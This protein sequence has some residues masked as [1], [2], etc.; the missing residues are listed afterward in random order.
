MKRLILGLTAGALTLLCGCKP[1][2]L[3]AWETVSDTVVEAGSVWDGTYTITVGVPADAVEQDADS[4]VQKVYRHASGEY[5]LYT[6]VFLASGVESA[7]RQLTGCEM[8]QLCVM[9]TTRFDMPEYRF[10]WYQP[11]GETGKLCR[12]DMV[13]DGEVCYAVVFAVEESVG[14]KYNQLITEVFSTFGLYYDEGI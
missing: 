5:E 10:T 3:P 2:Q 9:E 7:I 13:M 14:G 12:A 6:R 4:E 1:V 11:E 8:E